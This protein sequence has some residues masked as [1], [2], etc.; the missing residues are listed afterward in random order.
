VEMRD[1]RLRRGEH[2]NQSGLL[3]SMESPRALKEFSDARV[4]E[5]P[6]FICA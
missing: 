5:L 1:A 2:I 3:S 6:P 4:P